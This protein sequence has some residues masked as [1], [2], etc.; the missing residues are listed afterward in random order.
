[1]TERGAGPGAEAERLRRAL[2]AAERRIADLEER[3]GARRK[4]SDRQ[5]KAIER[6][7]ARVRVL[8]DRLEARERRLRAIERSR[9]WRLRGLVRR[10]RRAARG[11]APDAAPHAAPDTA[12]VPNAPPPAQRDG[13]AARP[14]APFAAAKPDGSPVRVLAI[15]HDP[16]FFA[17]IADYIAACVGVEFRMLLWRTS[18]S[19]DVAET[20]AAVEWADAIVCEWCLENAAFVSWAMRPDQRLVIRL[21][22]FELD[23]DRLLQIRPDRIDCLVVVSEHIADRA[24]RLPGWENVPVRVLW[25]RIDLVTFDRPKQKDAAFTLGLLGYAPRRKRLD[26]AL[27]LLEWLRKRDPRFVLRLK[28][29]P[30]G[31]LASFADDP[32]EKAYFDEV[33]R[34]I[35]SSP[36]L[37]HAVF[38]D[39]FGSDVPAWLRNI[40]WILSVSEDEGNQVAV[41]EAMA[42]RAVPVVLDRPGALETYPRRWVHGS[43]EQAANAVFEGAESWRQEGDDARRFVAKRCSEDE[44]LLPWLEIV[45]G[46]DF[47]DGGGGT[48]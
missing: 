14:A 32:E 43:I 4:R 48:N 24:R 34:R 38:F 37:R 33:H 15:T 20:R 30:L 39:Q 16:K 7:E 40:G 12:P 13:S 22:R 46:I 26:R 23:T 28:G 8:E 3:L 19:H 47:A 6:L 42:S 29:K 25:Q 31:A 36:E 35:D 45:L 2:A 10:S 21:H 1:M 9:W 18:M 11:V 27:D 5:A 44:A 41:L 17:D